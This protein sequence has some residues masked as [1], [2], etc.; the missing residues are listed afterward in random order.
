MTGTSQI[1][2]T[3]AQISL[4]LRGDGAHRANLSQDCYQPF[5]TDLPP[6]AT[7]DVTTAEVNRDRAFDAPEIEVDGWTLSYHLTGAEGYLDAATGAGWLKL[8][9]DEHLAH[10]GLA[11][12]L[13][14]AYAL[15]LIRQ[16]GFLFH[17]A[18]MIRDGRGYLFYGHSG[19]GKSTISRLSRQQATILSDDLVAVRKQDGIW[20]AHGTPFWGDLRAHP[21][22]SASAPLQGVFGLVKAPQARVEPLPP[23]LAVADVVS[24]VPTVCIDPGPSAQLVDLCADLAACV[25][26]YR[27]HFPKNN[28][29]WS[30]IDE[31]A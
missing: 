4:A 16:Q 14:I 13:R 1:H 11:N 29:F 9:A 22:T 25:P 27:L 20:Q 19:S 6:V 7:V 17:S 8:T 15:L 23:V 21:K 28:S 31:L 24:S 10:G 30:V 18:G 5:L 12:F 2:I 26:C 3:I